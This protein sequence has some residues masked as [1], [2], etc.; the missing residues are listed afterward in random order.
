MSLVFYNAQA[1][2][3]RHHLYYVSSESLNTFIPDAFIES[4]PL[5]NLQKPT[6]I[7]HPTSK[8]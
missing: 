1:S 4:L 7:L 2:L 3:Y 8:L 6:Y 5:D